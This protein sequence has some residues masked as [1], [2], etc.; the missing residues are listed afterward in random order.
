MTA[1]SSEREGAVRTWTAEQLTLI[2]QAD[3]LRLA[4]RRAEGALRPFTTMWVVRANEDLFVRS[5][6]FVPESESDAT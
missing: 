1:P 5:L 2:G 4:S 3:E 6:Q